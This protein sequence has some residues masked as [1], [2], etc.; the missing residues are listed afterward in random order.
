LVAQLAIYRGSAPRAIGHNKAGVLVL[1]EPQ[2]FQRAGRSLLR[3][4]LRQLL[5]PHEQGLRRLRP[6]RRPIRREQIRCKASKLIART[7]CR[8]RSRERCAA[9]SGILIGD[10][11]K[12]AESGFKVPVR[13]FLKCAN[14]QNHGLVGVSGA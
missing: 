13:A 12:K 5:R 9:K 11:S 7:N 10:W 4:Q 1:L 14:V 6:G 8:A 2:A 3:R